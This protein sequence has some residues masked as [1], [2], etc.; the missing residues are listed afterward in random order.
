MSVAEQIDYY[1]NGQMR[2]RS[3]LQDGE[4][5]GVETVGQESRG[6]VKAFL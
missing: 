4:L 6:K 2:Q 5:H 1:A 3:S